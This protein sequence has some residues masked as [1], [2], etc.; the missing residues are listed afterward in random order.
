M[1]DARAPIKIIGVEIDEENLV[2][3]SNGEMRHDVLVFVDEEDM[4]RIRAGY[5]CARCYEVQNDPF[6]E[7]CWV[8]RF[9]MKEKQSEFIAK[10]Y[11]GNIRVGPSTTIEEE[12]A[13]MHE[14]Q[15]IQVRK[16]RDS[17]LNPSQVWLPGS[18]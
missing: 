4:G 18:W 14:W 7:R 10:G 12:Y 11:R 9:P 17:I 3:N 16:K 13:V 2:I 6:P 5:A 1:R 15:E 8:C